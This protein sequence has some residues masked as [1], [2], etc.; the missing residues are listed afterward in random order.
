MIGVVPALLRDALDDVR[1]CLCRI[2][3]ING[4]ADHLGT[5][6][7]Q[8]SDLLDGAL[9]IRRVRVG[10]R[11]H[12]DRRLGPHANATNVDCYC[13]TTLYLRHKLSTLKFTIRPWSHLT[14]H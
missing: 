13:T 3:I 1:N 8:R 11:L 12:D 4:D 14:V 7:G 2:I 10:H 9:D 6:T 5:G